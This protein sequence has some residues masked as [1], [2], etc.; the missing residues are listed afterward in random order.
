MT[1]MQNCIEAPTTVLGMKKNE[2]EERAAN[3]LDMVGLA[4]KN[5]YPSQLSG[6][7]NSVSPSP[8]PWP[9]GQSGAV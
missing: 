3:L 8:G 4:K 1:A 6:G 9:C 7:S 5:H 2:A